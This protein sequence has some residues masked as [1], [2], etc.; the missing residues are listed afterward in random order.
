MST[1]LCVQVSSDLKPN[2]LEVEFL[3]NEEWTPDAE[4]LLL[5]RI[6][7]IL[8]LIRHD[9][10]A[11][12]VNL[13]VIVKSPQQAMLLIRKKFHQ[14][15]RHGIRNNHLSIREME[16]LELIMMGYTN[17]QIADKLFVCY[18]TVRSHRKHILAKTGAPNTA[19]LV[20]YYHQ[21]FFEK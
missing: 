16:I 7:E 12:S 6:H 20:T 18:E 14:R 13:D 17:H 21:T 10:I 3:Y 4:V 5:Q 2:K 8:S 15:T 1:K 11:I 19:A 9:G